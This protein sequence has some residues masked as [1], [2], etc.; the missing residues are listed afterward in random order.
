MSI[1]STV[2]RFEKF[3]G[4]WGSTTFT[5]A[6]DVT[7]LV[8]FFIA[9]LSRLHSSVSQHPERNAAARKRGRRSFMLFFLWVYRLNNVG[10][11]N[12]YCTV[13]AFISNVWC[14]RGAGRALLRQWF[15]VDPRSWGFCYQHYPAKSYRSARHVSA[16]NTAAPLRR[17]ACKLGSCQT[18]GRLFH[19]LTASAA[20]SPW[21]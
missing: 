10:M 6:D 7:E 16:S 8:G 21:I 3:T 15:L 13:T 14:L 12:Q 2:T 9:S 11:N 4:G 20:L 18:S 5:A 19:L 17:Q 1:L